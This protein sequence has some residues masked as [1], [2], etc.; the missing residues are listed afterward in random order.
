ML[1]VTTHQGPLVGHSVFA[2][3][4]RGVIRAWHDNRHE[5]EAAEES[6]KSM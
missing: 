3:P 4:L 1:L 2:E 5:P 6:E